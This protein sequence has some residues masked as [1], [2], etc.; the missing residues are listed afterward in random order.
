MIER[1][2]TAKIQPNL[3]QRNPS[4][5]EGNARAWLTRSGGK[6]PC[7]ATGMSQDSGSGTK[8]EVESKWSRTFS[9]YQLNV[10]GTHVQPGNDR[11]TTIEWTESG[12]SRPGLDERGTRG[13][14][15]VSID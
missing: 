3:L 9:H 14:Q 8:G 11:T 10:I 4:V 6:N 12:R 7:H 13:W 1:G 5:F 15:G 2:M